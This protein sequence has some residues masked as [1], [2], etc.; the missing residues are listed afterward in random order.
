MPV[1]KCDRNTRM[2]QINSPLMLNEKYQPAGSPQKIGVPGSKR[3][4][5][6][7]K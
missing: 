6:N 1:G 5:L 2:L 4:L 3:K 7:L